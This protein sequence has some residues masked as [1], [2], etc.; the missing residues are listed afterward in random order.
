MSSPQ[1][2]ETKRAAIGN[3]LEGGRL[4]RA[5]DYQGAIAACTE[6]I[7]SYP[8][9]LGPYSSRAEAYRRLGMEKEAAADLRHLAEENT[10]YRIRSFLS[11]PV[12]GRETP[13]VEVIVTGFDIRI[14][15]QP[16]VPLPQLTCCAYEYPQQLDDRQPLA[17][18]NIKYL[19]EEGTPQEL[20]L[21]MGLPY[22]LKDD[23][24]ELYTEISKAYQAF[25]WTPEQPLMATFL[26]QGDLSAILRDLGV[27]ARLA[28]WNEESGQLWPPRSQSHEY[29]W[30]IDVADGPIRQVVIHH[31]YEARVVPY[32]N[33]GEESSLAIEFLVPDSRIGPEFP[34]INIRIVRVRS[35][36]VFGKVTRVRWEDRSFLAVGD[37]G[38]REVDIKN[39]ISSY[40]LAIP[41]LAVP[42]FLDWPC[43][44]Q[45]PSALQTASPPVSPQRSTSASWDTHYPIALSCPRPP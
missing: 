38:Q 36:P 12:W 42:A 33:D 21:W 18:V 1:D 6:A 40:G 5:G 7:E 11:C 3:A 32:D 41:M 17:S 37:Q 4:L 34:Q 27:E 8:S 31:S 13:S 14:Q 44:Y 15:G 39:A 25:R 43:V 22:G 26:P 45:L 23:A 2:S 30:L 9:I 24:R 19:G 16:A 28:D 10:L 20:R 29:R 35:F